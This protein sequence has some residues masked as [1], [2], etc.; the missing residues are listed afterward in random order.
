MNWLLVIIINSTPVKTDLVFNDYNSCLNK[1]DEIS[2]IYSDHYNKMSKTILEQDIDE[3]E[4]NS[5]LDFLQSRLLRGICI[6]TTSSVT[7]NNK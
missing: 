4:K 2:L 5:S 7:I 3:H 1:E 6:P